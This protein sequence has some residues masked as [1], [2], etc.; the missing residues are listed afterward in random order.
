MDIVDRFPLFPVLVCFLA[1]PALAALLLRLAPRP[2][3]SAVFA[4]SNVSGLAAMC[5]LNGAKSVRLAV[6]VPYTRA[7]LIFFLLYL[8]MILCNYFLLRRVAAGRVPWETALLFPIAMLIYVRYLGGALNPF[9]VF[10]APAG[11]TSFAGFFVGISYLSFRAVLLAQEVR[12]EVVPMPSISQYLSFA[13]FPPTLSVGPISPYSKFIRSFDHPSRTVT[14]VGRSLLRIILGFTKY[15]V[16]GSIAAQFTYAGLLRD[17]HPH[18]LIDLL[19][20][21]AI[22]PVYLYCNFSGYC[23]LAIGVAGLLGIEVVENFDRPF[24]S[25]NFREFWTRWH[26]TLSTWIRDMVFTPL[27]KGIARRLGPRFTDHA[28]AASIFISFVIVGIWHGFGICFLLFGVT[29]GI[30]LVAVHYYTGWLKR[31]LGREGL[32]VYRQNRWIQ[33]AGVAATYSYFALTLIFFANSWQQ[34]LDLHHIL[35]GRLF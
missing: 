26:I 9:S 6:L 14:P 21:V 13:C 7:A 35:R 33:A 1:Y 11:L 32:A 29:Q 15:L 23:D 19:I 30:G 22:F 12:N 4:A 16:F 34:L 24:L 10:L 18:A 27:S 25:R 31:R 8:G 20:A 2:A 3:R 28:I 5:W 17:G